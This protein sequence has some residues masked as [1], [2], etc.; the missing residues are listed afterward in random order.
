[1]LIRNVLARL[2]PTERKIIFI[3][4]ATGVL[5]I[6]IILIF[7]VR[8]KT[9]IVPDRGG[10]LR[11]GM[12]GQP[13]R[14]LPI[15]A[16]SNTDQAL[17]RLVFSPLRD[18]L[19]K[20]EPVD[21]ISSLPSS[22]WRVRLKENLYWHDK[23]KITA[24]DVIFTIS[25][26]QELGSASLE[27][28]AWRG[29]RVERVSELEF[30]LT[31]PTPYV[32]FEQT[33]NSLQ[34]IPKHIFEPIPF[35]QW[36]RSKY[37]KEPVGSGSF[38]F[39][40]LEEDSSGFIK[41][42]EFAAVH[43]HPK[44]AYLD[45]VSIIFFKTTEEAGANFENA[46]IDAFMDDGSTPITLRRESKKITFREP[47]I[48]AIYFNP[49]INE[50]LRNK[51]VR[52]Y[53]GEKLPVSLI[54]KNI[55]GESAVLTD[56]PILP[57]TSGYSPSYSKSAAPTTTLEDSLSI[58]LTVP[59]TDAL[60]LL[61]EQIKTEWEKTGIKVYLDIQ[62]LKDIV[63]KTIPNRAY[64]ALLFGITENN[65]ED[66]FSFWHSS[67]RFSPGLNLS[68]YTSNSVDK[69]LEAIRTETDPAKRAELL[70]DIQEAIRND[71]PAIFLFSP[72]I[73]YHT[74]R[75]LEG[76]PEGALLK[77]RADYLDTISGWYRGTKR[78]WKD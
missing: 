30:E 12:V 53:L 38:K 50:S 73:T 78:E 57:G 11:E 77:E 46:H 37:L 71:A 27:Y 62:D 58:K 70:L 56:G 22:Q 60:V 49:G 10:I 32:F 64:E 41:S 8:E 21:D 15:I 51:Q 72:N 13:A 20:M 59:K 28:P 35:E 34:P 3:A 43:P 36:S 69:D 33:I 16:T 4:V 42:L 7:I 18:L 67:M 31:T 74:V 48:Y 75:N 17:S 19:D 65:P 26:I 76:I 25:K 68:L 45:R 1:M 66:I 5:A 40:N 61:G 44:E 47:T 14:I 2:S 54:V 55:F 29:V 6:A 63:A 24:D 9:G 39:K 23:E 52:K